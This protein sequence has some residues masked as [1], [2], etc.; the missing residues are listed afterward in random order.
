MTELPAVRKLRYVVPEAEG[1]L[2]AVPLGY[3]EGSVARAQGD[4][5]TAEP[6]QQGRGPRQLDAGSWRARGLPPG[7]V[8]STSDKIATRAQFSSDWGFST[9]MLLTSLRSAW[10]AL[11][12]NGVGQQSRGERHLDLHSQGSMPTAFERPQIAGQD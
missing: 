2:P 9:S 1:P 12:V 7:S 10:F 3:L 11:H 4:V 6:L 5:D 8:A